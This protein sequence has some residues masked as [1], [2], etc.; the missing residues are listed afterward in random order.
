MANRFEFLLMSK[1]I[2][3]ASDL[4]TVIGAIMQLMAVRFEWSIIVISLIALSTSIMNVLIVYIQYKWEFK[5]R[6]I[7]KFD[8][9]L[10][11]SMIRQSVPL[12]IAASC[13]TIYTRCDSVMIGMLM[14][15]AEVGV[16]SI[17]LK[18]I[19]VVQI[20]LSPVRES[21][22]PKLIAL[23]N[24]DIIGVAFSFFILP[25]LFRFLNAEYAEAFPIY[26]IYVLGTFFMYNAALRAGHYT[27]INKGN[28]LMYTQLFSLVL[29][30]ILNY[31]GISWIGVYGAAVAT[32]ITQGLSLMISN[33]FF[34]QEGRDVFKWQMKALNPVNIFI[35]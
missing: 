7:C 30:V 3:V 5:E 28:I 18:L 22:Y 14:T 31:V 27:M 15:T 4:A 6:L 35:K 1:K 29:N 8:R 20:T 9:K 26:K 2:V 25:F 17:S 10:F 23:Y 16:Y 13:A 24:T 33:L 11:K 34:G 32:I 21:V 12:A 19:S